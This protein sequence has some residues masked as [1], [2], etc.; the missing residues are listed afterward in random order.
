VTKNCQGEDGIESTP[1]TN[2]DDFSNIKGSSAKINK[3]TGEVWEKDK[4]HKDH[5][6]VYKNKNDWEKGKRVRDVWNDGRPKSKIS[7]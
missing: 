5:W 7:G 6:E 4:L 1:S 2:P 3:K